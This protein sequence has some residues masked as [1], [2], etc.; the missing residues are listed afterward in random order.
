MFKG[1]KT[2]TFWIGLIIF[3]YSIYQFAIGIWTVIYYS[4]L[5]PN[6]LGYNPSFGND[7]LLLGLGQAVPNIIGGVIFLVIGLYIMKVG[8][9]KESVSNSELKQTS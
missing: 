4:F 2:V 6:F 5:Y 3:G 7:S 9:K 1:E 8:L